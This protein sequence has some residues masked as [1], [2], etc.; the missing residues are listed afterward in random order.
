MLKIAYCD[1]SE[2]DR[3]E[4]EHALTKIQIQWDVDFVVS[5]HESGEELLKELEMRA[6]D[7]VLLDIVMHKLDGIDTAREVR[8]KHPQCWL[9]FISNYEKRWKELLGRN[10]LAFLDKPICSTDL[11][12]VLKAVCEERKVASSE[13]FEYKLSGSR[14]QIN[15]KEVLYW[16]SEGHY[17]KIHTINECIKYKGKI[18][19]VWEQLERRGVVIRP[20]KSHIVNLRYMSMS[21]H[22]VKIKGAIEIPIGRSFQKMSWERYNEYLNERRRD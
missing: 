11:E 6:Y 22:Y 9:I 1:D 18:R 2:K 14:I 17:V 20:T 16:E 4:I 19:E 12:S 5:A 15:L 21:K 3:K 7:I 8:K 10:T 13:I